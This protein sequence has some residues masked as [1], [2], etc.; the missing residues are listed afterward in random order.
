MIFTPCHSLNKLC[1]CTIRTEPYIAFLCRYGF[2]GRYHGGRRPS[3]DNSFH[4]PTVIALS[5]LGKPSIME[6][7]HR[8]RTCS[9]TSPHR[10]PTMVTLHDTRFVDCRHLNDGWAV[11]TCHL[12][13]VGLHDTGPRSLNSVADARPL[14]EYYHSFIEMVHVF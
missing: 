12:T 9:H 3:S 8:R 13:F 7:Y 4:S 6:C 11:K 10:S 2:R 5:A 14:P 1:G